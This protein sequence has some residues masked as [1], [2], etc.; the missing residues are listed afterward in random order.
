MNPHT[1]KERLRGVLAFT[2]TPFTQDDRLDADGLAAHVDYL[3][4]RGAGA[5]V[6]CGGTGEF[7]SLDLD[8]YRAAIRIAAEAARG[9]VPVL[10]GIGHATRTA[11]Q[12]AE[13]A[14]AV[15]VAGLLI[16]PQYFV[17]APDD[18]LVLHY[19]TLARA[20]GLGLIVFS[21]KHAPVTPDLVKRLAEIEQVVAFKDESG[22]LAVFRELVRG[23]GSR[24]VWINGM[25]ELYAGPYFTA[26]AQ[27]FT[28]GIVN[29]APQ[30][31][32]SVWR[33]GVAGRADELR[34]LIEHKVKPLAALR[35]RKRGYA[36]AVVKEA[37]N[38]LGL[39]GGTVRP[40][41]VPVAREDRDELRR[42]LI[43][44]ELLQE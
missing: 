10:A 43:R 38:L 20:T 35:E 6:V 16:H 31:T 7:F 4:R 21:T 34:D 15:G 42:V 32:L 11:C 9:Q 25:G 12:L 17:E 19:Q 29:F 1:L 3:A 44:L 24:L 14:A 13:Y 33:A 27:A 36:I 23:L 18:G 30:I 26:G 8:E 37:M 2:P 22:D 40:P 41:L 28:S 39:P 5:I